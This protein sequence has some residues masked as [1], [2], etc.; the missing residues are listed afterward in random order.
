MVRPVSRRSVRAA[1]ALSLAV[2]GVALVPVAATA[3]TV[4]SVPLPADYFPRD[5]APAADGTARVLL[6]QWSKQAE[7]REVVVG[8]QGLLGAPLQL[9]APSPTQGEFTLG[10]LTARGSVISFRSNR[11]PHPKLRAVIW[12]D[13]KPVGKAQTISDPSRSFRGG[14]TTASPSGAAAVEFWQ[15][16]GNRRWESRLA[17]RPAGARRFLPA[18][19]VSPTGS[20]VRRGSSSGVQLWVT[21]GPNGDGAVLWASGGEGGGSVLRRI[22]RD[23]SVGPAVQL[24]R[25]DLPIDGFSS[26][27]VGASGEIVIVRQT[28]AEGPWV[29]HGD[30]EDQRVTARAEVLAIPAG[31]NVAG[32]PVLLREES[33]WGA[34]VKE[35]AVSADVD[36]NGHVI[37]AVAGGRDRMELFEGGPALASLRP[38]ASFPNREWAGYG[39]FTVL[40]TN[41]GGGAVFWGAQTMTVQR[42]PGGTW[43]APELMLP[44]L[45]SGISV[46]EN[47]RATADGGVVA[48]VR[49]DDDQQDLVASVVRVRR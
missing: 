33:G 38:V 18:V 34:D 24:P 21:W 31:S 26:I 44:K 2:A 48:I 20:P 40:H 8:A 1:R 36:A 15:H 10:S 45:K 12:E 7:Q 5:V 29:A 39:E 28:L 13:G 43:S 19:A 22:A 17:V 3:L 4:S 49:R 27:E 47:A 35:F 9:L 46:L 11:P 41:D 16:L 25:L 37:V 23:G 6:E 42:A 30:G 14:W 32:A